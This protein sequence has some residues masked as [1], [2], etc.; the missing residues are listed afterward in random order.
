[1]QRNQLELHCDDVHQ[2]AVPHGSL[3]HR[4][5][6]LQ[7]LAACTAVCY[8]VTCNQYW[9]YAAGKGLKLSHGL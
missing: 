4:Q 9:N 8:H 2:A 3:V 5:S 1:M 7:A 6:R